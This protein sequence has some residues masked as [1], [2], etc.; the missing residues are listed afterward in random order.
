MEAILLIGHGSRVSEGNEELLR[1]A[2]SVKEQAQGKWVETCFLEF[3]S[4]NI[5][6]GIAR[7]IEAGATRV[8]LVPI[9]LFGAGHSK[10]HIPAEIDHAKLKYPSVEFAYGRPIGIHQKVL[11][12]LSTRLSEAGY[13]NDLPEGERDPVTAVLLLGRGS[14]DGDANSD[15][16]KMS[17]LLW[18]QVPVKW[19]ESSFIG[20]TE[21]TFSDGLER[22]KLL[23]AKKIYILPYFLFTGVLI[24]RIEELTE[25]FAQLN[26]HIQVKLAGYFGFHPGLIDLLLDRVEEAFVGRAV[27]N[28]DM[29]KY[30]KIAAEGLEHHHHHDDHDHGHGHG[31]DHH[32]DE[33]DR[34]HDHHNHDHYDHNHNHN[35]DEHSHDHNYNHDHCHDHNHDHSHDHHDDHHHDDLD[36]HKHDDDHKHEQHDR[37]EHAEKN[38]ETAS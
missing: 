33:H 26:P 15:F 21:P 2:E 31:H 4:P 36:H 30:R 3:A 6:Q 18:E 8:V 23:G 35:H 11:D 1:F 13:K 37:E 34:S 17:R 7:C 12:I 19:V 27:M 32:H 22:C 10:I 16:L 38:K 9:I 28:C 25:E 14:S 29:C 20:V 5:P 24:K